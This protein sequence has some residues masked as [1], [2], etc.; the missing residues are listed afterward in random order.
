MAG[1]SPAMMARVVIV[2]L[3]KGVDPTEDSAVAS[4]PQ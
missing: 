2:V 3:A 4:A 1:S